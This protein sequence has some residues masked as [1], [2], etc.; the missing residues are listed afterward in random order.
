MCGIWARFGDQPVDECA[1]FWTNKLRAR[2]PEKTLVKSTHKYSMGFTRLAINGL[3]E[4]GMQPMNF[5]STTY[6]CN[7][8]IYNWRDLASRYDVDNGSGSD[9]EVLGELWDKF[10]KVGPGSSFF[11]SLDGVFAIVIADSSSD[12][13]YV[14]RDPYGVRPLFVGYKFGEPVN[15]TEASKSY[16]Q[17]STGFLPIEGLYFASEMKALLMCNHIEVFPP[18]H[19]A[20]YN[21][22][23]LARSGLDAYHSVPW[24]KNPLYKTP[25][26]TCLA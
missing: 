16:V 24:L 19:C 26:N 12:H 10:S 17:G 9:C 20:A 6:M 14:A 3:N 8:E 23:T 18:G 15:V 2:G 4:S 7:G 5:G 13:V 1:E 21:M 22:T 25:L 11:Q